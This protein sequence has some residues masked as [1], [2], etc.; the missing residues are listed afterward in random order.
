MTM[1]SAIAKARR[2][3]AKDGISYAV[4][5]CG[6]DEYTVKRLTIAQDN[7]PHDIVKTVGA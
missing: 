3:N 5:F 7:Y 4:V 6:S 1:K 2:L